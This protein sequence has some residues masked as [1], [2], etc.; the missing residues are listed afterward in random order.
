MPLLEVTSL[1]KVFGGLTAIHSLDINVLESEILGVI[2]PN[3]AGK[4]TLFN[5][6]MGFVA[7]TTG[8]VAF[9][10]Q[11][12][13]GWKTDQIARKRIGRTFQASILFM[14]MTVFEN[15]FTAFHMQYREP[16]WK[17]V[18][19][20][21]SNK[22]EERLVREKVLEVLDFMGILSA[23]DELAMNLPHG[24]QR[25]LG[26]C[27]AMA[28]EPRIVL[29]DEPATGMNSV[30]KS[31]L[32]ELIRK[33]R[34]RGSTVVLVEHDMKAVTSLCDRLVVLNFGRK[35][36]EGS[37]AQVLRQKDVVEAYLGSGH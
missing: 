4:S 7:P 3:G 16:R 37:P 32:V 30:E 23:K 11:D 12:I 33:L 22:K 19:Q 26:I 20:T 6:I 36:A 1:S 2:G 28:T 18:L 25:I 13:T 34:D 5:L 9:D 27:M 14:Q 31:A 10:G 35:I 24:H 17:A 15:V 8:R 29:L 21:S